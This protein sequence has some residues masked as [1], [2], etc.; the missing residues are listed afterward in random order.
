MTVIAER[1]EQVEHIWRDSFQ[2]ELNDALRSE[3]R[4]A[5]LVGVKTCLEE[6]LKEELNEHLGFCHYERSSGESKPPEAQ[7]SGYFKRRVDTDH[8]TIPDLRVPKLR[9]GNKEREWKILTRYQSSLQYVLSGLLYIY[10]MGLSIRDLQEA[11]MVM[12]GPLLSVSALITTSVQAQIT[13]RQQLPLTKTPPIIIVDGVWVKILYPTGQNW[14]DK[15]GV[16][17]KHDKFKNE[18]S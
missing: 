15:L 12:W 4:E 1:Q 16:R 7:R 3:L 5:A 2:T 14:V 18:S 17:A 8:G 10:M 11:M 13:A 9:R 6:A